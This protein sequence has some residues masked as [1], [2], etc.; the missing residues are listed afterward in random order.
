MPL[1]ATC[2]GCA[3]VY[4]LPENLAGKQV[5]CKQCQKVFVIAASAPQEEEEPPEVFPC[6]D[7]P[8]PTRISQERTRPRRQDDREE[9]RPERRRR[10]RE[11]DP[12]RGRSSTVVILVAV[13]GGLFLLAGVAVAVWQFGPWR[14]STVVI[15]N[16]AVVVNNPA[17]PDQGGPEEPLPALVFKPA[18]LDRDKVTRELPGV[19]GEVCVGGGGRFLILHLPSLR[20]LAVFDASEARIV[21]FLPIGDDKVLLAAGFDK[22]FVALPVRNQLQRWDLTTFEKESTGAVPVPILGLAMGSGTRGPLVVQT[23]EPFPGR[24]ETNLVCLDPQTF[25]ESAIQFVSPDRFVPGR[26][27]PGRQETGLRVSTDGKVVTGT[28]VFIRDGKNYRSVPEAPANA[29]PG[30]DGRYLYTAGQIYSAE[31]KPVGPHIGRHGQ[32]SWFFPAHHG[33]YYVS[34]SERGPQGNAIRFALGIHQGGDTQP[35][36]TLPDIEGLTGLLEYPSGRHVPFDRHV[37]FIPEARLL[38]VIPRS[39]DRL[40]LH[41]INTEELAAR[42]KP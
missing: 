41:R 34:L 26:G 5:R 29:T 1:R 25:Q 3:A 12:E 21:K 33:P 19:A 8:E 40:F 31:G 23:G 13:A 36:V 38:V 37:F 35:L 4:S 39:Q 15:N 17:P 22:L 30:A 2:P 7:L 28:G 10:Q 20:Q 14:S 24:D 6:D 16:P 32:M 9:H 42:G 11:E 27:D 18:P